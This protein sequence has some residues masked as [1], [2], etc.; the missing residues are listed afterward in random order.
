MRNG[1]LNMISRSDVPERSGDAP[2]TNSEG[3]LS[4]VV[5]GGLIGAVAASSCCILPLV[6][7]ALGIGG[8]WIGNLTALAPYQP[9]FIVITLGIL[10]YGFWLVYGRVACR[11]ADSCARPVSDRLLK[12]GLWTATLALAPPWRSP[13][14]LVHSSEADG[15]PMRYTAITCLVAPLL[16][17]S[18]ALAAEKTVTL[19]VANMTCAACPYIVQKT[20]AAVPGVTAAKVSFED[21]TATVTFDDGQT[22][23]SALTAA[24]ND[25][26]YPSAPVTAPGG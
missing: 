2:A 25:A 22:D 9:I 10:A 3:W 18:A 4:L 26:G 20:L 21:K 15:G 19:S 16:T 5:A 23:V 14:W 8:A 13:L 24:T 1:P 17:V 11:D 12:V 6:L 7:F